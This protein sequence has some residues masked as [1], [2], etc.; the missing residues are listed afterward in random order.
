V[1]L[2]TPERGFCTLQL[3]GAWLRQQRLEL[4]TDLI[5]SHLLA[6]GRVPPAQFLG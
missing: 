6:M 4:E 1:R 3:N 5:A 2:A